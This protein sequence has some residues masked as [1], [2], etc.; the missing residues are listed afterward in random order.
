ML[1][2]RSAAFDVGGIA[3]IRALRSRQRFGHGDGQEVEVAEDS[4][5]CRCKMQNYLETVELMHQRPAEYV[6]YRVGSES[7]VLADPINIV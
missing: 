1:N 4:Q 7:L 5:Y 6:A 2:N 3:F